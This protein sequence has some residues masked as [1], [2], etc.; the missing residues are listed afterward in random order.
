MGNQVKARIQARSPGSLLGPAGGFLPT[1]A[2]FLLASLGPLGVPPG[3]AESWEDSSIVVEAE[4]KAIDY[5]SQ[6]L[7]VNVW[8]EKAEGEIYRRGEPVRAHFEVNQDAYAVVYRIDAEG[9]V[10][11]L[12][13]HS[14]FNDGFV[15]GHHEYKL[16]A[17]GAPRV[18]TAGEEGIEYI[19]A[20]VSVYP[21]DLRGLEVDFHH[22]VGEDRFHFLVAGDPFLA[23][24][25]VNFAITGL[26]DRADYVVSNYT[27]YYVH[28]QVDHPRYL[29]SQCHDVE[30]DYHPYRD[31]CTVEIHY[32]YGWY[33]SW[34]VRFGYFPIYY[35]P[36][37]YYVDP[38]TWR[39]WV[40]YWY[41]PWY[42]WPSVWVYSWP[43]DYY[44]WNYSP[45]YHGDCWT[46]YR[47]GERR[48]APLARSYRTR[49]A[50]RDRYVRRKNGMVGNGLPDEDMNDALR[51]RTPLNDGRR[52]SIR[53]QDVE[54]IQV[55]DRTRYRDNKPVLR[56]RL[57]F[58]DP[59]SSRSAPG[60]RIRDR[61]D[62]KGAPIP[63]VRRSRVLTGSGRS[64]DAG[65][66][67]APGQIENR[68]G[69]PD[70]SGGSAPRT[71]RSGQPRKGGSRIWSGGRKAPAADRKARPQ[72]V[73]P[74]SRSP[75][76]SPARGRSSQVKPSKPAPSRKSDG[77]QSV[78]P[79]SPRKSGGGQ[80][81]ARPPAKPP[82]SRN[83]SGKGSGSS[84]K[85]R[86]DRRR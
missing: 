21:F 71:I 51:T 57:S 39:P 4:P 40:H 78:K 12:W 16:P 76:G 49:A 65:K 50:D 28:R 45:Y 63:S 35:Y 8:H 23:M 19:E 20:I 60:L 69:S 6:T 18:R 5:E 77:G 70:K 25:E 42:G 11:I 59:G 75:Q 33:N 27:S 1:M 14:R 53:G 37:Y 79:A 74:S 56:E 10:T 46:R 44:C 2:V 58:P 66:P 55:T 80:P 52:V 68:T 22:E 43:Y 62:V 32:D 26:E 84:Q 15:F 86:D 13:P 81:P 24:N 41:T 82:A 34:Y 85:G 30:V 64:P 73:K 48:Y 83:S 38:W 54:S 31:T 61:V 47:S 9:E 29:C 17:P 67:R 36:A 7:R 72:Q 3:Q